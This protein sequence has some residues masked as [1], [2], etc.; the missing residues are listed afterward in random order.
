V[1]AQPAATE[2]ALATLVEPPHEALAVERLTRAT[3][4]SAGWLRGSRTQVRGALWLVGGPRRNEPLT[5]RV[6]DAYGTRVF[7]PAHNLGMGGVLYVHAPDSW[8]GDKILEDL[9]A[10]VHT[11]LVKQLIGRTDLDSDLVV[12]HVAHALALARLQPVDIPA[13]TFDCFRPSPLRAMPHC[14]AAR[15]GPHQI[16]GLADDPTSSV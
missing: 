5:V 13:L 16:V 8:H 12:A 1:V 3:Q 2:R 15:S 7:V 10:S 9:C 6:I 14:G 11:A 4:D